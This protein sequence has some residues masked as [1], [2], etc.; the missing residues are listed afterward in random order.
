MPLKNL[1]KF[2][3]T[4]D[5]P[6]INCEVSLDLKWNKN[7]VLTSKETRPAGDDPVANPA[8]NNPT[9]AK[10]DIIDCKLYVPVVTLSTEYENKLY[11]Q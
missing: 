4:L 5:I 6:L 3:R 2:L 8:I 10:S 9:D 11:Q 1:S 7:C